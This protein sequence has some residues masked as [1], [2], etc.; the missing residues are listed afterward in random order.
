MTQALP[1]KKIRVNGKNKKSPVLQ[2][3]PGRRHCRHVFLAEANTVT[4][5]VLNVGG[6]YTCNLL[7]EETMRSVLVGMGAI[8]PLGNDSQGSFWGRP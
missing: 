4:R 5:T 6:S 2:N 3:W 7:K 1:E 8:T